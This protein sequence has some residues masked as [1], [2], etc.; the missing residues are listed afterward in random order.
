MR[1]SFQ[2]PFAFSF[3]ETLD[4]DNFL[5][6]PANAPLLPYLR[7]F[8][9][10]PDQFCFLWGAAGSGKTHLL[11][12][13]SHASESAVYLPLAQLLPH[14]PESLEGL[15]QFPLLVLDDLQA[16]AGQ[17]DWEEQLF[18]L[19]NLLHA[20]GGRICMA[21]DASPAQLSLLL[22]DLRSRLQLSVIFEVQGLDEAG[23]QQV[24]QQRARARGIELKEEEAAYIMSRSLRG[25]TDLLA[26]LERLDTLSLAEKR[27]IT[28][29]FIRST[30]GW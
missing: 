27:R 15:D 10:G 7:A 18:Q 23:R 26:V 14:G 13:L 11:Q 20:S 30:F 8:E 24:L 16:V 4:F 17:R 25:M 22:A 9:N 28:I 6:Q 29:P 19:F 12:A 2:L 5:L 1:G 21:A 3:R